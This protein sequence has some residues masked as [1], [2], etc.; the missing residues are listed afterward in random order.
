MIEGTLKNGFEVSIPDENLDD[1]EVI[2][3]LAVL[4]EDDDDEESGSDKIKAALFVFKRLLGDSQYKA[5]KKH[6]KKIDGR[7]S[8]DKM[9]NEILPEIFDLNGESKN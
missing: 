6:V 2:E 5:L 1:F 8:W 3:A 4:D 7:I 9:I